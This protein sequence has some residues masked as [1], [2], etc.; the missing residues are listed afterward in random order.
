M[1]Y[2]K[3]TGQISTAILRIVNYGVNLRK[4]GAH[5]Q[6][7]PCFAPE[8]LEELVL[9]A[10]VDISPWSGASP[11]QHTNFSEEGF[12]NYTSPAQSVT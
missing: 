6:A 9:Y 4:P 3:E 12:A 5:S 2:N 11:Y 7:Y 8:Q 10:F 1:H